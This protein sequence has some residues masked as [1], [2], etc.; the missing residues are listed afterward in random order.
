M[1]DETLTFCRNNPRSC[2]KDIRFIVFDRNQGI[3]EAFRQEIRIV[4]E[5][6]KKQAMSSTRLESDNK[7]SFVN[8][9]VVNGDLIHEKTD[10]I[11][12]MI[13]PDMDM[14]NAGELSKAIAKASG[15]Q[16]Q[17][18][19]RQLGQQNAGSAVITTGGNLPA[20]H[21]IHLIPG[22]G[23]FKDSIF[24]CLENCL[25]LAE[26][27]GLRSMSLPAVG[28]GRYRISATES[29]GIIF[30]ALS[31]FEGR[32]V[33]IQ[34]VRIVTPKY[35]VRKVFLQEKKKRRPIPRSRPAPATTCIEDNNGVNIKIL[36]G[37]LT[38]EDTDAIFN[39]INTDMTMS[40]AGEL[41]KAIATAAGQQVEDQ[42]KKLGQQRG[43]SAV[44][45]CG[46]ELKAR[47][48]IHL[49][50]LSSDKQH[51]QKCL[52]EGLRLA[53]T[54]GFQ[55]ISVPA[56][57]TGGYGMSAVVSANM[58]FQ[59]LENV[60]KTSANIQLVRIVLLNQ[61]LIGVFTQEQKTRQTGDREK[62][63]TQTIRQS[64]R[65]WITGNDDESVNS[66]ADEIKSYFSD[67]FSTEEVKDDGVSILSKS[68]KANVFLDE[69]FK[70]D[71]EMTIKGNLIKL[72]GDEREVHQLA[73]KIYQEINQLKKEQEKQQQ[74]ENYLLV[75]KTIDWAYELNGEKSHFDYK[76]N[77]NLEMA[78]RKEQPSVKVSLRGDE[79]VIDLKAKLGCGQHNGE[80]ITLIR[81]LKQ[82]EG[83]FLSF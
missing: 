80:Q 64:V 74:E 18:E 68:P 43:G 1:L 31:K 35:G 26:I 14:N 65:V 42:C 71:V 32:F 28:T 10:A 83:N 79:F 73:L 8:I 12:N 63:S 66:S 55:S 47:H 67:D 45:T 36:I 27:K 54:E 70:A 22:F 51:L 61:K 19:C 53:E 33:N 38:H 13:G 4:Q 78:H 39:I 20:S 76:V 2:L 82:A 40:N 48:I 41:S 52:E 57:G 60:C 17:N 37:D 3:I 30:Q 49:I 34:N 69:A 6:E 58:I 16:L 21:V 15:P 62:F 23:S 46:G 24:S 77:Y 59:A 75:A 5:R 7:M 44:M 25:H 9:E 72:R 81:Q 56:I 50:P 11:V 29:A